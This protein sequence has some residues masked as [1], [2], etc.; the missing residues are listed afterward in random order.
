MQTTTEIETPAETIEDA[1]AETIIA[2]PR[3][4]LTVQQLCRVFDGQSFGGQAADAEDIKA[5]IGRMVASGRLQM[6]HY[7]GVSLLDREV[8]I[9]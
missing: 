3:D 8:W 2:E 9:A 7:E 5:A 4:A 6:D 1:I